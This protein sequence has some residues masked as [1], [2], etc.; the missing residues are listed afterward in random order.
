MDLSPTF[1]LRHFPQKIDDTMTVVK[2]AA[3]NVDASTRQI[4]QTIAEAS[5]PTRTARHLE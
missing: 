4:R 2:S 3:S 5:V 1:S